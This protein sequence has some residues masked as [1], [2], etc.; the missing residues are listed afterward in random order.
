MPVLENVKW[1]R[2]A[3]YLAS[4]VNKTVAYGKAGFSQRSSS[5][6]SGL[7]RHPEI[8][9]RVQEIS[10]EKTKRSEA[11][12]QDRAEREAISRDWVIAELIDNVH[13]AKR[14][15]PSTDNEGNAVAGKMDLSAANKALHLLGME[16][17]MFVERK[18]TIKTPFDELNLSE[19]QAVLALL[20]AGRI[21]D[22]QKYIGSGSTESAGRGDRDNAGDD[23][24]SAGN[25]ED[26]GASA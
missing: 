8:A 13:L 6:A 26:Q 21:H 2:F 16:L 22:G 19:Q 18:M 10:A 9:Q 14:P 12:W 15:P 7:S 11:A 25:G 4:G 24:A 17:G 23:R 3:Q 1:E 20:E 5:R